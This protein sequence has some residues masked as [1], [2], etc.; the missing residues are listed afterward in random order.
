MCSEN[1]IYLYQNLI[2]R[3]ISVIKSLDSAYVD[4]DLPAK[5]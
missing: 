2:E 3:D 4:M 5:R 1:N